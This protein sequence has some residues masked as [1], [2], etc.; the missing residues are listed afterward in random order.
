MIHNRYR[1]K[2]LHDSTIFWW[3]FYCSDRRK[4]PF[5][6]PRYLR[7]ILKMTLSAAWITSFV[8]IVFA[9]LYYFNFCLIVFGGVLNFTHLE[10]FIRIYC[11]TPYYENSSNYDVILITSAFFHFLKENFVFLLKIL[12]EKKRRRWLSRSPK[13]FGDFCLLRGY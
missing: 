8:K 4:C 10:R 11:E 7:L 2:N 13:F 3:N 6:Q 12:N 9:K 1:Q 5:G